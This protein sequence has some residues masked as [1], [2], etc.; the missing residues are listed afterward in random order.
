MYLRTLF[1]RFLQAKGSA[2][3]SD[4]TQRLYHVLFD[5]YLK[6]ICGQGLREV[7]SNF[8]PRLIQDYLIH[9]SRYVKPNSVHN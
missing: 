4:G 2:G 3:A 8:N 7:L 1:F 5:G 9:S 6:F